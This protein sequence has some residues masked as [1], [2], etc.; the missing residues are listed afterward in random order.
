MHYVMLFLAQARAG[1][2]CITI[3]DEPLVARLFLD[4]LAELDEILCI[5]PAGCGHYIFWHCTIL[6]EKMKDQPSI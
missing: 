3:V 6:L 5:K 2:E 1:D 4:L